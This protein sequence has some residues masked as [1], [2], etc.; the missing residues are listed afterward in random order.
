MSAVP[1]TRRHFL[2]VSAAAG[3]GMIIGFCIPEALAATVQPKPWTSLPE[4]AEINAWLAIDA[5]GN[6][7]IR[8][9]H[10]EMGQ[11]ALTAV[12]MMIAEELNVDWTR[13]RAVFADPNRH[14]RESNVYKSMNTSGSAVVRRQHPHIMQAGASARERL[15][16]A[17]ARAWGVDRSQVE[18][19]LGTLKAGQRTGSYAEFATAAS[20]I[21][22]SEEPAI[23]KPGDWWLLG[24]PLKRLDAEVKSNGT[25]VYAIDVQVPGMVYAAVKA[26]PA[27]WGTLRG[28]DDKAIKGRP[29]IILVTA[30]KAVPSKT[31]NSDL[32]DCVAVVADSWWRA[33]NALEEV[34][35]DWD[36]GPYANV[37]SSSQLTLARQ[38]LGQAGTVVSEK[39]EGSL[40]VGES[41]KVTAEY[42]RP[43]ETH[44]RMEPI[45]A[46]V[47]VTPGR[48][49]VWSPTQD[50]STA[51]ELAADQAGRDP[52]DVYVHT[53][54]L[55]GGFGGNGGGATAVTRQATE[56]SK[57]LKRP[58][59][60]VWSREE[61][62]AQDKQRPPNVTRLTAA[63]RADG[64][65]YAWT[66]RSLWYTQDGIERVG[67]A[68]AHYA[69]SNMPYQVPNRRHEAIN[70]KS[71]VPVATHRAPGTNQHGF[72]T[73]CFVDEVAIAGG[74][75]PLEWR[76]AM[77]AGLA[78]WQLVLRTLKDKSGFRTDLPKGQGMGVAIVE[79]HGSIC[80]ACATVRVSP[81]GELKVEKVVIVIDSGHVINPHNTAEQL[82]G[83]VCWEL[84]HAWM[85]GLE[86][87]EGR[88]VNTNFDSYPLLRIHQMPQVE[89]H[90]ALS[91]GAKWG[92]IGEPAGPPTPPAVANAIWYATGKRIRSTPFKNQDL[93]WSQVTASHGQEFRFSRLRRP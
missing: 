53:I 61:D 5:E 2:K 66:T 90:F 39:S 30:L 82:E 37:S 89:V 42:H 13:V 40:Y 32:Q 77:T 80:A 64:L 1:V 12:S 23:K 24:K 62:M 75:D 18:A 79:D 74:W 86:M 29:G 91:G 7:T 19:K 21:T 63:L 28:Y 50:Q 76:L 81:A 27:P 56:L 3:G 57:R 60:V 87:R 44:A 51:L 22:L 58:V 68:T 47:S 33:K 4:G 70:A 88:F 41:R 6:V 26:C 11:G 38:R 46:T 67:P 20:K 85:G 25:A 31:D 34:T 93:S 17:A 36:Y 15:K 35:I 8:V 49:D 52:K 73:E 43:W 83:G 45:N 9:P 59:K 78:D 72:I 14:L 65:P 10:T 16:E 71:H 55:G 92:G 54:F 69:I 84:S 48:V